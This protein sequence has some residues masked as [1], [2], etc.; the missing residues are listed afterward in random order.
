MRRTMEL[1][2]LFMMIGMLVMSRVNCDSTVTDDEDEEEETALDE[3]ETSGSSPNDDS[4]TVERP[5]IDTYR[6]DT[7]PKQQPKQIQ[8]DVDNNSH[9][10]E[11]ETFD[12]TTVDSSSN[13]IFASSD[14]LENDLDQEEDTDDLNEPSVQTDSSP[15]SSGSSSQ[16][17]Q[18]QQP[19]IFTYQ[20]NRSKLLNIIKKPGILA[21][22]VGGA[23]IGILTAILLIMFIVYR[24]RKKDEGSYALEET[25]KPLHAAYDYRNCPTK[26]FYA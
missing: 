13:Q 15:P 4:P 17:Q 7:K 24:M 5:A 23:I 26:E 22:I 8:H 6:D 10:N 25:K 18:P 19:S 9:D 14:D 12:E 1:G 3:Y 11:E 21:G 20:N 2:V 16:G